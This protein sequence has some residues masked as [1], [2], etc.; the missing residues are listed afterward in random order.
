MKYALTPRHIA[1]YQENGFVVIDDFLA[2]DELEYWRSAVAEAVEERNG[3]KMP[4]KSVKIGED[5]GIN[6][7]ADYFNNVFDQ[8]LNL[9]QT[10]DKIKGLMLDEQIGKMAADLAGVDGIRIWHDQALI[11]RPWANPTA[12]HLD[13]PFWSFYDR[14]ALSI[15]V[16]LDDATLENGCLFF[17]PGSYR[18]TAFENPGIGKNMIEVFNAYPQFRQ[19]QSVAATMKAGSCSFHNGLTIHGANAN[20]TPG[21]RRA[22]TCAYMPDGNVFNGQANILPDDYLQRIKVG[23][24]LNDDAQNPLI[25]KR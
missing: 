24:P 18:E 21:F 15:W 14:R 8:L 22:M 7:D 16:A 23:D 20:M 2:P 4:G 19:T 5:D 9:W 12:W 10:N 11:K 1:D 17:I 25:Y 13:T 3:Q 6:K